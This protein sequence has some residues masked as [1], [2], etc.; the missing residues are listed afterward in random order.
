[1]LVIHV[2]APALVSFDWQ[3]LDAFIIL[4]PLLT[5]SDIVYAAGCPVLK[6]QNESVRS[7]D[8]CRLHSNSPHYAL[9]T[10]DTR[11]CQ[12]T[13]GEKKVRSVP[14][15]KETVA[16]LDPKSWK[17]Y[18]IAKPNTKSTIDR[19]HLPQRF[20]RQELCRKSFRVSHCTKKRK[21]RAK[22]SPFACFFASPSNPVSSASFALRNA[23][24]YT[25]TFSVTLLHHEKKHPGSPHP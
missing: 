2:V 8:S 7:S 19:I 17:V 24:T 6:R 4:L 16:L 20:C 3:K 11:R 9:L 1:M 15:G 18:N 12:V 5:N 13:D 14:G 22:S 10:V 25:R 23:S 21:H